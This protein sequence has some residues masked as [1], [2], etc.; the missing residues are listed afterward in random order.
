MP[1]E[2]RRGSRAGSDSRSEVGVA[3]GRVEYLRTVRQAL[4]GAVARVVEVGVLRGNYAM[5][6]KTSLEPRELVLVDP[7]CC[8]PG[9]AY[10]KATQAQWDERYA[11]VV[12]RFSRFDG[13]RILRMFSSEAAAQVADGS[14]D[15]VYIDADH[16]EAMVRADLEAWTPKVRRGGFIAGHDFQPEGS[17]GDEGVMA[18]CRKFFGP[19]FERIVVPHE[20]GRGRNGFPPSFFYQVP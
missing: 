3:D 6:L 18:A 10:V 11:T 5:S 7:W 13:I 9:T 1:T 15:L 4:G 16:Q 17:P 19:T 20:P 2:R 8:L 14:V 12:K